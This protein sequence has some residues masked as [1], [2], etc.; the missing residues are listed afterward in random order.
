MSRDLPARI[1]KSAVPRGMRVAVLIWLIFAGV[2]IYALF[3]AGCALASGD[4]FSAGLNGALA[5]V[6]AWSTAGFLI[7]VPLCFYLTRKF[8]S[9]H[10]TEIAAAYKRT[11]RI[12]ERLPIAKDLNFGVAVAT[13]AFIQHARGRFDDAEMQ[14]RRA[15]KI[16]SKNKRAAYPHYAVITNN[17]AGLLVR[18][19]R[20][21]EAEELLATALGIWEKQKGHEWNGSAIPLCTMASMYLES[22]DLEQAE[23]YLLNARRR[24]EAQRDPQMILPD[25]MWQCRTVCYLGLT[26]V[27]CRKRQW[28]DAFKFMELALD[29]VYHRP[30]AFGTLSLYTTGKIVQE[31]LSAGKVEQAER[32]LELA[33]SIGSKYPDHPD[34]ISLLD[35]YENLLRLTGRVAEISDMRRW[36][37]PVTPM[38][39]SISGSL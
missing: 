4:L 27:Y 16:M 2:F 39:R 34:A 3:C 17:Y 13:L 19:H 18:E 9:G 29:L 30:I 31:L 11:L 37:R 7:N 25:S 38:L 20:F 36:I 6:L 21:E 12:W 1:T 35:H 33:Y 8:S 14:Y 24:F 23:N 10:F 32:M 15:I 26:L 5:A 28:S 22:G